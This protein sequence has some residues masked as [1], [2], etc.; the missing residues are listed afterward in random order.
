[1]LHVFTEKKQEFKDEIEIFLW[2]TRQLSEYASIVS[3][4]TDFQK[5]NLP[6]NLQ[7][8]EF[9]KSALGLFVAHNHI[10]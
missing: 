10:F 7:I 3:Q 4:I 6:I 9:T 1:M 5:Y 2:E 8:S